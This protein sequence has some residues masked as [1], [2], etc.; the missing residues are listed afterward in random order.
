MSIDL[1]EYVNDYLENKI[2]SLL[3]Y[4]YSTSNDFREANYLE[5]LSNEKIEEITRKVENDSELSGKINNLIDYY[6]YH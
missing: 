5:S 2:S 1:K 4:A 3:D 6:I